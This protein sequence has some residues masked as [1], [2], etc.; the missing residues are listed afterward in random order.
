MKKITIAGG[1]GLIGGHL[2][3]F[4]QGNGFDVR[5]L[6]RNPK[7]EY[8]YYW[9]PEQGG[10][11]SRALRDADVVINLA[12]AGIADKRWTEA[13]KH[14]L[15]ESRVSGNLL[16]HRALAG[17]SRPPEMYI[18]ASAIGYYGNSGEHL[19][20]ETDLP[21][22]NSFMVV[23]C[24]AWEESAQPIA[25]MG[26]R[27]AWLRIGVVLAAEG[28]ALTEITKPIRFGLGAYFGDGRA[29][30]PWIH[31]VDICRM[32]QWVV[33]TPT[34]RGVYNAVAPNPVRNKEFVMAVAKAMNQPILPAP[35]PA[36]VLKTMMGEMSAV[37]LNSNRVSA[38]KIQQEGFIFQCPKVEEALASLTL[39]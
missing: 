6:T 13:R 35:A 19:C 23:C 25:D 15:I 29:W 20:R 26:I 22:D 37:V 36:F 18:S 31:H 39:K 14:E 32:M 30:F 3:P 38:D 2:V 24:K 33:E 12:G 8:E 1:T 27:T 10:I 34:A 28:G 7:K 4:L 21:F 17:M 11:D 9:N 16:L 5:V